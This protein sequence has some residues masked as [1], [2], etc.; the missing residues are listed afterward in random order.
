MFLC[1]HVSIIMYIYISMVHLSSSGTVL[2]ALSYLASWLQLYYCVTIDLH[3]HSSLLIH[4]STEQITLSFYL[5]ET[6]G[7]GDADT[8]RGDPNH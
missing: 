3:S 6:G 2:Y 4:D 8:A 5:T 1:L 7:V